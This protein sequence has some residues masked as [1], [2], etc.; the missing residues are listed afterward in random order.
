MPKET[1]LVVLTGIGYVGRQHYVA[2]LMSRTLEHVLVVCDVD[3]VSGIKSFS[4][5]EKTMFVFLDVRDTTNLIKPLPL[6][7]ADFTKSLQEKNL[8]YKDILEKF[9]SCFD[10]NKTVRERLLG[11][12]ASSDNVEEIVTIITEQRK[13]RNNFKYIINDNG[14]LEN[15]VLLL[16]A[17]IKGHFKIQPPVP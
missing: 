14:P 13:L 11:I 17:M 8:S 1:G 2:E 16:S 10:L 12:Q 6:D 3:D 9:D 4:D 5:E 7:P 15:T